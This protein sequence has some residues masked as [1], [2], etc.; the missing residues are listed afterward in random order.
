M[1]SAN[2]K[3]ANLFILTQALEFQGPIE[4]D[5]Q[6]VLTWATQKKS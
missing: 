6:R 4:K 3:V 1:Q 5:I 2:V